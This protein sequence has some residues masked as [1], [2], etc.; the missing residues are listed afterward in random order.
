MD[1]R[2]KLALVPLDALD[3]DLRSLPTEGSTAQLRNAERKA[4]H[5]LLKGS[6]RLSLCLC[7]FLCSILL[8]L[9]LSLQ[10]ERAELRL[11]SL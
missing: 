9:S 3:R 11:E 2:D 6:I 8:E 1:S 4:H 10:A 5:L 7:F